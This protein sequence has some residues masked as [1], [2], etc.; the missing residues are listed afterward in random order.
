MTR[1]RFRIVS[2]AL[3]LALGG[4][5]TDGSADGLHRRLESDLRRSCLVHVTRTSAGSAELAGARWH[6]AC[7]A[8][9]HR[10][11]ERLAPR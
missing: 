3:V 11:A 2:G 1:R 7:V 9:A 10:Q 5:V 8:W 4:C 6:T